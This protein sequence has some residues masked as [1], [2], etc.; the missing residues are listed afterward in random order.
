MDLSIFPTLNAALNATSGL[1]VIA[2]LL[3]VRARRLAAH[4]VIMKS[5]CGVSV[6]FFASY[7]FYHAQVGSIHFLGTGWVRPLYFFILTT[8]T[9]LAIAIVPL[10]IRTVWLASHG[11]LTMHVAIARWTAPLWLYVSVTGVIVYVMLY[12]RP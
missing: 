8:H 5:A 11:R 3:C 2:G 10:V 7:L 4:A 12:H 1:L 6:L 9:L